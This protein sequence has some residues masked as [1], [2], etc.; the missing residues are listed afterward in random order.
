LFDKKQHIFIF[1]GLKTNSLFISAKGKI[2]SQMPRPLHYLFIV[3]IFLIFTTTLVAQQ[4]DGKLVRSE[5][6]LPFNAEEAQADFYISPTG[7]DTWSG[8]LAGP[9]A[10]GTDGPFATIKRAKQAVRELKEKVYLPKGKPIDALYV[11]TDHPYGKGKDIVVFIR[12]GFYTLSGPLVFTPED[13]GERVETNLP[14]G[15]FEWHHLRDNY[16]TYSAYPGEKPVISGAVPVTNWKKTGDTW[17]APFE[18]G[19]VSTL[20]ADGKKQTLARIPN[21]GYFTLTNTPT[22]T[23]EIPY[24]K[25]DI[26]SWKNMEDNRIVILL[27]W[28]TAYNSITKIDEKKQIAYLKTPEDGPKGFNGLLVVPPR[29]YI[30]NVKELLDVPGE[31][32]FDKTKQEISYIPADGISDPNE[33]DIS[34]PQI[35]Q[36]LQIKG[37][38]KKPVRNLRFYGLTLEGAKE[39]FR[40]YPHYYDPTPGC[41]AV[42]WEY[43]Q[44]CEFAHSELRACSGVGMNIGLGCYKTRIFNNRFDGLGQGALG[45]RGNHDVKNGKTIQITRETLVTRN[46][47]SE[48]GMEGGITLWISGTLFTTISHNYFTKSGRPYTVVCGGGGLEGNVSWDSIIEYN[49][50]EDVQHDA[51]D[52]GV[53][54]VNGMT[55]N[56]VV[57]NNLIHGVHRGYFSDNVAFWFDNMSSGWTVKNNIYYDLEQADMKICG[58]YMSD[59]SYTDNFLIGPPQNAPERFIEGDPEIVCTN[60]CIE[61]EEKLVKNKLDAGSVIKVKADVYNAGSSGVAQIPLYMNRKIVKMGPFPVIKNNKHTIE[62]DLR[63]GD[64]GSHEISIAETKP[65]TIS[66][67]GETPTIVFDKIQV[68]EDRILANESVSVS[69]K[70]TNLQSRTIETIVGLYANDKKVNS[71]PIKLNSKESKDVR[72]DFTLDAGK[73]HLRIENSDIVSLQVSKFKELDIKK[74]KLFTYI[75]P[76]A[77]PANVTVEQKKNQ[78]S[79]KASGWDFYHA[80]DAYATAYLKQLEGDFIS[81]V[82]IVSFANRTNEWFRAGLFVRNDI[83]KSFD[84]NRGSKGSVLMF[85]TPGRAGI[86]YDEFGDGCMHHANSENLPENT[87]TPIWV[88]LERH[89]DSFTGYT[90]L[91]GKNWIIKRQTKNIPGIN[92]A[93]DLGVAAGSSDQVQYFVDFA[94]WQVFVA[95]N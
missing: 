66:V 82:K 69:A 57:R 58:T 45:I 52:A 93:I 27:R 29:Y 56:S 90:S 84:V 25:G 11:G 38:E 13:G 61:F 83:T 54:V 47:F 65:Q 46:V 8:I 23:S 3:L 10:T 16:V 63:L 44:E 33:I 51:D 37:D 87:P 40:D 15:A 20:I 18:L 41:V 30:D 43:A 89:G 95:D 6:W 81:T 91:D 22:L 62:F 88:R 74:Q 19:D 36:L 17:V 68:S 94:E 48:C 31:W 1:H 76:K 4:R 2:M 60:L 77:K 42:T 9:N 75:S 71:Q 73:Y 21:K 35:T 7:N 14:S 85:S 34:V 67:T 79:I 26:K 53:I 59:N 39:N 55:R 32:F 28:R 64:A 50:F 86:N 80:E 78:Y 92:K 24:N 5:L 49:H 70:A 72:F 12:E